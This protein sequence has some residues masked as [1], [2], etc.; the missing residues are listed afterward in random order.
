MTDE[1]IDDRID[2]WHQGGTGQ[3]LIEYL[4]MTRDEYR[5]WVGGLPPTR[6]TR[7]VSPTVWRV[8]K[9]GACGV[10]ETR[11]KTLAS[12]AG[13]RFLC[14]GCMDTWFELIRDRRVD[15]RQWGC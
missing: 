14:S 13:D 12:F 5:D 7:R 11:E 15:K 3:T 10:D 8:R 9:C 4:G 1:E 2:K 6:R